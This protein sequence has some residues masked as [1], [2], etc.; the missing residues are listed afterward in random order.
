M[1]LLI[2]FDNTIVDWHEGIV[3][4]LG[5]V[6]FVD[7]YNLYERYPDRTD[8]VMNVIHRPGFTLGLIPFDDALRVLKKLAKIHDVYICSA[9]HEDFYH[10]SNE[11][12]EWI[13]IHLGKS[14]LH[15]VILTYDKTLIQGDFLIDD[16]PIIEGVILE[17]TWK[18]VHFGTEVKTWKEIEDRFGQM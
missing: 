16:K 5:E 4:E 10:S 13:K 8:E 18:H 9:T 2:D 6:E 3:R 1:R 17:P 12:L 14:W 11:K 7:T 15:K